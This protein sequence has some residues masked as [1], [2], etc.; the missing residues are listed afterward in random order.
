MKR[1][2]HIASSAIAAATASALLLAAAP[3]ARAADVPSQAEQAARVVERATGVKDLAAT[4]TTGEAAAHAQTNKNGQTATATAPKN[5]S[6]QVRITAPD[7]TV[8]SLGLPETRP[9]AGTRTGNGTVVYPDAAPSTDIAVQLTDDGGARALAALKDPSAPTEQH[10]KL[11]LPAGSAAVANETGGYDLIRP[12]EGGAAVT[13]GQIDAPWAKDAKGNPVPTT[14][15]LEGNTLIQRVDIT[16]D[17]AFP[18]VADPKWTWGNITGTVYFNKGETADAAV[19]M[20]FIAGIIAAGGVP[21]L[22]SAATL[23]NIARV[24][25]LAQNHGNCLKV[26]IPILYPDEYSGGNCT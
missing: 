17:T 13:V 26:K 8:A 6:D 2:T 20:S 18:V 3:A 9:T 19:N 22:L 25:F 11:D 10:Y 24:A 15:T 12:T 7:G 14:Y 16:K 1:T 5:A 4:G 23:A 21:G